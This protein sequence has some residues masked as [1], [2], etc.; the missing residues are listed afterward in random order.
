MNEILLEFAGR[1]ADKG[2]DRLP[3][4]FRQMAVNAKFFLGTRK[5]LGPVSDYSL[6]LKKGRVTFRFD[7]APDVHADAQIAGTLSED[8]SFMW[9]WGHP[10]V[11]E[12]M[13][14]AAWA[15]QQFGDRQEIE[16]LLTRG[17]K[18]DPVR[19]DEYLAICAYISD[20]DGVYLGD[21]GGGGKVCI[22][23]YLNDQLKK[24]LGR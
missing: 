19:V 13:Q 23:Y 22:C 2:A 9:G 6:N 12:N 16:E 5:D 24:V 11:P 1:M 18:S 21:H 3:E 17:G 4:T 15:V 14:A 7:D 8:G 10:E 20:A